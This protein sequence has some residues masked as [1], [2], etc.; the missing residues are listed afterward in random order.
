MWPS[1][2]AAPLVLPSGSTLPPLPYLLAVVLGVALVGWGLNRAE[3]RLTPRT[4]LA[5]APWM[6]VGSSFYVT[7]QIGLLPARLAP[8]LSSPTVYAT[9]AVLAGGVWL[10]ATR[11]G[12]PLVALAGAGAGLLVLPAGWA[13]SHALATGSFA[14]KWSVAAT[15][16]SLLLASALW[17]GTRHLD[18]DLG[19][20]LNVV[21]W[22]VVFAHT[23]DG[24]STAV[25]T[26]QLGFGEQTPLSAILLEAGAVLPGVPM[27]GDGWLYLLVKVGIALGLLF[28]LEDLLR[29]DPPL[30]NGLLVLIT[31]VGLGPATHNLLLFAVVA[32]TGL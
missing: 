16:L 24:V 12:E 27:L 30:G 26:A 3:V 7:Y 2:V 8:F 20:F 23:L 22:L 4:V 1:A 6:V 10:L 11:T 17:A 21:G 31:A 14:P 32:P 18:P 29:D 9:T 25:G 13:S 5:L 28:L 19:E 15:A